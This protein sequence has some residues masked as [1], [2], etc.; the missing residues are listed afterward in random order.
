MR[1]LSSVTIAQMI[2]GTGL[3]AH[4]VRCAISGM[5]VRKRLG[6]EVVTEKRADGQ[7]AYH[8]A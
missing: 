7:R 5:G 8:I 6:Y 3:Q 1:Q 2:S 4:T